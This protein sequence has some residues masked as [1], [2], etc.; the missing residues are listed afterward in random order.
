MEEKPTEELV[1]LSVTNY[2][3]VL[4]LLTIHNGEMQRE[5]DK[6]RRIEI[7]ISG[8]LLIDELLLF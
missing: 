4:I 3:T 6:K 1:G 5:I 7:L 2:E 8:I